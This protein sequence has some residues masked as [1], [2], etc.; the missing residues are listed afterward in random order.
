M[1]I[2][3]AGDNG[4]SRGASGV[5]IVTAVPIVSTDSRGGSRSRIGE[6]L[7]A[8]TTDRSSKKA[9]GPSRILI[10]DD[11][12]LSTKMFRDL[13]EAYGYRTTVVDTGTAAWAAARQS[14]PDLILM[15]IQ[16]PDISGLEVTRRIRN[17]AALKHIPIVA[18]TAFAMKGD[19]DRFLAAGCDGYLPKPVS[20]DALLD[21]VS[22]HLV[23]EGASAADG[24][25]GVMATTACGLPSP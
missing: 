13:L 5:R 4:P 19:G 22:T 6:S 14:P 25:L 17:D 7:Q 8:M 11:N 2:K 20:L 18:V 21:A 15:D 9:K 3:Q 24:D 23:G 12:E 16:L 1:G 10:V